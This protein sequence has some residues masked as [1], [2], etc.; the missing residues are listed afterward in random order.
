MSTATRHL[1]VKYAIALGALVV[2]GC[3]AIASMDRAVINWR[4]HK[5]KQEFQRLGEQCA[6]KGSSRSDVELCVRKAGYP[7][8]PQNSAEVVRFSRCIGTQSCGG[9]DVIFDVRTNTVA[10][11]EA[12]ASHGPLRMM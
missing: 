11:W 7:V 8:S 2:G 9:L 12:N 4:L 1:L 10:R 6:P 3:D 5:L